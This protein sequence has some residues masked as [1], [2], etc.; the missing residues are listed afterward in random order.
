M[1]R[2]GRRRC[3]TGIPCAGLPA[4]RVVERFVE[5]GAFVHQ[6]EAVMR[7]GDFRQLLVSFMLSYEELDFLRKME[8]ITFRFPELEVTAEARIHRISPGFDAKSRKIPVDL[9]F[10]MSM[11]GFPP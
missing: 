6:G 4:W 10:L 1:K 11:T 5:E 7:L 8:E 3:S 2:R 9:I